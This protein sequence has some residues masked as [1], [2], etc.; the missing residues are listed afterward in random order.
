VHSVAGRYFHLSRV[1][2]DL[3]FPS[4]DAD[5]ARVALRSGVAYCWGLGEEGCVGMEGA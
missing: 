3:A 1:A 2:G 5:G 4:I